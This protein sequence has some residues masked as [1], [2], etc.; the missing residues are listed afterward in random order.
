[1]SDVQGSNDSIH[2]LILL[3][4]L[5]RLISD[6]EVL[7]AFLQELWP[8]QRQGLMY[9]VE[10]GHLPYHHHLKFK[11]QSNYF[12]ELEVVNCTNNHLQ[13]E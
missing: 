3:L 10:L 4:L 2:N 1:M 11:K 9:Q 12:K 7:S 6:N 5:D 8:W 13:L